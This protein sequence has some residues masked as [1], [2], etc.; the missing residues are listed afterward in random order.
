[1]NTRNV[2]YAFLMAVIFWVSACTS[3]EEKESISVNELYRINIGGK[4]GF[5]NENGD[6]VIEPQYDETYFHFRDGEVCF[7]RIGERKGL[8]NSSGE[9]VA[10]LEK[11]IDFVWNFVNGKTICIGNNNRYGVVDENG[12]LVLPMVYSNITVDNPMGFIVQDT[13]GNMGYINYQGKLILPCIY[14]DVKGFN[15]GLMVV[16]TSNKCGYVDTLGDWII[17]SIYDDARVFNNGMA[18]VKKGNGW[19]FIDKKGNVIESLKYEEILTG[20]SDNRAFVRQNGTI[21][22]VNRRGTVIKQIDVDSVYSFNEGYAGF[23]KN[24]KFGMLDT[25]GNVSVAP[26]YEKLSSY[27]NGLAKYKKDNLWGLIDTGG[28]VVVD[29]SHNADCGTID[30][31]ALLWG[32]DTVY[33]EFPMTYYDQKGNVIWK[34]MPGN[35]FSWPKVPTKG[36]FIAYFDTRLSELDPIEGVYYVSFNKKAVNRDNGSSSS[37]G[38]KSNFIAVIRDVNNREEFR[39]YFID[40]ETPWGYWVKKFVRIGES[41]PYAVMNNDEKSTW[42]DDGKLILEDPSHFE[43]TLRQGGNNWYNWY[44]QCDFVRDYPNAAIMEQIQQAE[45]TGTGFAVADGYIATN[46]HVIN[47]AKKINIKGVNEDDGETYKGYVVATDREHDLAILRIV[48]KKFKGLEEAIP[49]CVGKTVPEVGDDVFV[50]GYPKTNTMGQEVKLTN[51]IISAESGFKGDASMYQISVPVQPGNSGGPLFDND[52]NVI[53]VVCAK[54]ADAENANY[55]IKVSYLF[56]LVN[57]SGI[58]IKMP[59]KNNVSSKSLSKTVKKVKPFVYLIE[60]CSH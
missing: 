17:D 22:M 36:D 7:A 49:Y 29:A 33:N 4:Y 31:Y 55:A 38:T 16:A 34:D 57:S 20:F 6:V 32:Q 53:G 52:G 35:K 42:A 18:R 12:N 47:G 9:F 59:N 14:D 27:E 45:W 3:N 1:M 11:G 25:N 60:C 40:G 23:K 51:G 50:L 15:E 21:C 28:N 26:K 39:A 58:G 30:G 37:N 41:N 54:H 10:E 43:V 8:I 2:F 48:D 46:Y 5:I 44:V 56:S 19:V 24:G 13:L